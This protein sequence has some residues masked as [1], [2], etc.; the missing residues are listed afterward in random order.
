MEMDN[1]IALFIQPR[2]TPSNKWDMLINVQNELYPLKYNLSMEYTFSG[3][4]MDNKSVPYKN[5]LKHTY[6]FHTK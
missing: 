3:L 2:L 1:Y 5:K 6:V 4:Y